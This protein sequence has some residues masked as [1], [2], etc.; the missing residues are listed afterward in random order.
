MRSTHSQGGRIDTMRPH[1]RLCGLFYF[2][3]IFY[4]LGVGG[5]LWNQHATRS[6]SPSPLPL[7]GRE[8]VASLTGTRLGLEIFLER[9]LDHCSIASS[10]S[11][12]DRCSEH[13]IALISRSNAQTLWS[14]SL[15]PD[16]SDLCVAICRSSHWEF[17]LDFLLHAAQCCKYL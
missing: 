4:F 2:Y 6:N 7:E 17:F 8:K 16:R 13:S 1:Y 9:S 11:S 15:S 5:G 14:P 12:L 3:F 10:L